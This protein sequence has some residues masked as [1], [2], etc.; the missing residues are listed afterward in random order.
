MT[1]P[2]LLQSALADV[3]RARERLHR[4]ALDTDSPLPGATEAADLLD[5]ARDALDGA[6]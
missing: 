1:E 5:A 6:A 3:D 4:Y 2:D